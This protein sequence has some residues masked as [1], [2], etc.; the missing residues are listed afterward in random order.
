MR[1]GSDRAARVP[2]R[3]YR[4]RACCARCFS[5]SEIELR[6]FDPVAAERDEA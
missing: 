6:A 1:H 4:Y 3:G 2:D 5:R